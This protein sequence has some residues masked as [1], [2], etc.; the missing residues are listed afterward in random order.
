MHED[1]IAKALSQ[2]GVS[3]RDFLKFCTAMAATLA[4]PSTF[5][6]KIAEALEKKMKP[7]VIWLELSDCA[8]DSESMLR[9]TKPTIAEIVLDVISLEYH[10]TI[11]APSGKAAE[12]SK[13]DVVKNLK[14]K[15]YCHRRR[16]RPHEGWRGILHD[17]RTFGPGHRPGSLRKRH[18]DLGRWL[19]R[20]LGR[21]GQRDSQPNGVCGRERG[22]AQCHGGEPSRLSGERGK[23]HR[24]DR[25][26]LN[27]RIAPGPG[28]STSA[29]SSATGRESMTTV[30][31]ECTSMPGSS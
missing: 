28:Q 2:R 9:A 15:I 18:G 26:F 1:G 22:G 14:G 31:G 24:N 25:S 29:P 3:R 4:L 17:R 23:H 6:P 7:V 19:L 12:K 11:M 16:S 13:M 5:V 8:G 30:K 10:E 21:G 27:L 20:L